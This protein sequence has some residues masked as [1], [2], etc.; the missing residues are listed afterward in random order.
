MQTASSPSAREVGYLLP[1][2]AHG[3]LC[4]VSVVLHRMAA[5]AATEQASDDHAQHL[6][7]QRGVL[8]HSLRSL[9]A[10]IE[11]A[12]SQCVHPAWP[13]ADPQEAP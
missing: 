11:L 12:L 10:R 5:L 9:S 6:L 3:L 13:A 8:P 2:A 1:A 4:E 7:C